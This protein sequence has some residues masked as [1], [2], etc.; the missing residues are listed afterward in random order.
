MQCVFKALKGSAISRHF[1]LWWRGEEGSLY[2]CHVD[3]QADPRFECPHMW[4]SAEQ[5]LPVKWIGSIKVKSNVH[6][7]WF[8][9]SVRW[10]ASASVYTHITADGEEFV[11]CNQM[12]CESEVSSPSPSHLIP[13]LS[14]LS[15]LSALMSS[16]LSLI[17]LVWLWIPNHPEDATL[18]LLEGF[19]LTPHLVVGLSHRC[20]YACHDLSLL[21]HPHLPICASFEGITQIPLFW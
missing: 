14:N 12:S 19:I 4:V 20:K 9:E 8:A 7:R 17:R 10:R 3:T 5:Q 15:S 18:W 2:P 13:L 11:H 16:L 1:T 21:A 6:S